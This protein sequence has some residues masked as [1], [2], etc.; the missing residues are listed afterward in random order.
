MSYDREDNNDNKIFVGGLSWETTKEDLEDYFSQYGDIV[1]CTVITDPNTGRSRGY[2]FVT[3]SD[4]SSISEVEGKDH[5]LGGRKIAPQ[6]A[7]PRGSRPGGR[8]GGR[9]G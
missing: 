8:G 4:S 5:E 7:R 2:G 1:H 9:V 3:Y 6:K